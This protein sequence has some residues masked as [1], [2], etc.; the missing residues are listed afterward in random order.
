MCA[1]CEKEVVHEIKILCVDVDTI[2][3]KALVYLYEIHLSA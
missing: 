2:L 3:L 1:M